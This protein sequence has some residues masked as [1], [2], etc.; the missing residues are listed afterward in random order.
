VPVEFA[1]PVE[2]T[3]EK[4]NQ[5]VAVGEDLDFQRRWWTFERVAWSFFVLLLLLDLSGAFGRG[6]LAHAS[7][8]AQDQS[9]EVRYDRI[10]RTGTPSILDVSFGPA[11]IQDG[12]IKLY[13]SESV[14]KELGAQRVIPA[15]I[16]TEVGNGGL[17]YTFPATAPPASVQFALE[18]P[19]MGVYRFRMQVPGMQDVESRIV[20]VP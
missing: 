10:E 3:V 8:H 9:L 18:P 13:V 17:T 2:D 7:L 4:I 12:K 19:S 5:E 16:S 14:V 1:K 15:P 6:P 11:A 20:V